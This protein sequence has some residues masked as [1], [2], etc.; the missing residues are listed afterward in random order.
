[1]SWKYT[2]LRI[3]DIH[4]LGT[5]EISEMDDFL[6]KK[7]RREGGHLRFEK[8]CCWFSVLR[9]KILVM[10]LGIICK[11]KFQNY[12]GGQSLFG[13][14]KNV[15]P[16]WRF[17]ASLKSLLKKPRL[18]FGHTPLPKSKTNKYIVFPASVVARWPR[19]CSRRSPNFWQPSPILSC[20][21]WFS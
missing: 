15:H 9:N 21:G 16:F 1:M 17:Q 10:I 19:Q 13:L 6:K 18:L 7:V 11:E 8:F 12:G 14:L 2:H 4:N 5:L 3:Y 20:F